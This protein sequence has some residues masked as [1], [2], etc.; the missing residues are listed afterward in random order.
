MYKIKL[1]SYFPSFCS[2]QEAKDLVLN[3][4]QTGVIKSEPISTPAPIPTPA[5]HASHAAAVANVPHPVAAL[6][7]GNTVLRRTTT[8]VTPNALTSTSPKLEGCYETTVGGQLPVAV[9]PVLSTNSS[10]SSSNNNGYISQ[11]HPQQA[12][13]TTNQQLPAHDPQLQQHHHQ[14]HQ[15][16]LQHH[17]HH[18][19]QH[20]HAEHMQHQALNQQ[21]MFDIMEPQNGNLSYTPLYP[22]NE[23]IV[24]SSSSLGHEHMHQYPDTTTGSGY[25]SNN[26]YYY[27]VDVTAASLIRPYSANSNSCSSS[28]ESER[29]L[30]T[31]NASLVNGTSPQ[32]TYSDLSHS[33]ELNYFSDSSSQQHHQQQQQHQH[34]QHH[35]QHNTLTELVSPLQG[36]HLT[37]LEH[38]NAT[39]QHHSLT[40]LEHQQQ[41]PHNPNQHQQQ[42]QHIIASS[43]TETFKNVNGPHHTSV[44]V[45]PQHYINNEFVH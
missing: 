44:I 43:F 35:L 2:E 8:N 42:Q 17:H 12:T 15:T 37:Q 27:D 7:N 34:Q 39:N 32:T 3:E 14:H 10:S 25:Y 24:S 36:H 6:N 16:Q 20:N 38:T 4:I 41:H 26:N 19:H 23:S 11:Q 9:T 22:V 13:Q 28:S 1:I 45:E 30:S 33:F 29:Q 21:H 40:P 18:H 5:L 31:G